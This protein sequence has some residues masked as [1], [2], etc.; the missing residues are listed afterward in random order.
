[1]WIAWR[2][3]AMGKDSCL[4]SYQDDTGESSLLKLLDYSP[5]QWLNWSRDWFKGI[6]SRDFRP[7]K[8]KPFS[9]MNQGTQGYRYSLTKKTKRRKSRETVPLNCSYWPVILIVYLLLHKTC[10]Y[11]DYRCTWNQFC[12]PGVAPHITV[13]SFPLTYI[14][15]ITK[16]FKW[17]TVN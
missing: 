2:R 8:T 13:Y 7:S 5:M 1:M 17:Y 10:S 4:S 11:L 15:D 16:L 3:F 6:V 12:I 14:Y 9:P